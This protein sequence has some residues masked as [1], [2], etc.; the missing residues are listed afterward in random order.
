MME[1]QIV[2]TGGETTLF[3]LFVGPLFWAGL[4]WA[5]RGTKIL[6]I[7][8]RNLVVMSGVFGYGMLM[9]DFIMRHQ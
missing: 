5:N 4:D 9:V 6:I 7:L 2:F 3:F 1:E 8:W